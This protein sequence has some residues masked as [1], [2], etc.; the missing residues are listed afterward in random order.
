[1]WYFYNNNILTFI[2]KQLKIFDF[3]RSENAQFKKCI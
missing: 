1:M 2:V 3:K